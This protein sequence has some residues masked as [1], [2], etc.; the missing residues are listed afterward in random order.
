MFVPA[1]NAI[2]SEPNPAVIAEMVGAPGA[3]S[4]KVK[5]DVALV[6]SL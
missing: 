3:T 5:V 1:V 6:T 2:E 4:L